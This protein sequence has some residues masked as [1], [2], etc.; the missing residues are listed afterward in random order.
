MN[1]FNREERLRRMLSPSEAEAPKPSKPAMFIAFC[2]RFAFIV[3]SVAL[4]DIGLDG[5]YDLSLFDMARVAFGG[6]IMA[7]MAS[8]MLAEAIGQR[9]D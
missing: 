1:T 3:A 8:T 7:A 4:V 6:L 5:D 2:L 9:L